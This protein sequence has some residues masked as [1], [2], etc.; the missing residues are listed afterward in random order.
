MLALASFAVA[1]SL[2]GCGRFVDYSRVVEANRLHERGDY[3]GAMAAYLRSGRSAF[4]ATIDYDIANVHARLGEYKEATERYAA[5]RRGGG[6][7]IAADSR[8]NEGVALFERGL[9]EESWKS[10]RAAL[11][12]ADGRGTFARDAR[13]NLELAWRAW[14]KSA[15]VP[16]QGLTATSRGSSQDSGELKLLQ[17]LETGHWRPGTATAPSSSASDY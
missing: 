5:A 13:R 7:S 2:T 8:F 12:G 6:P 3:Q 17:R 14:K 16:A 11:S 10:F 15:R 1:A 9:Y 4:P